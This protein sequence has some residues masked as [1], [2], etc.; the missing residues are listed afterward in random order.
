MLR[1]TSVI[2]SDELQFTSVKA[3]SA[4]VCAGA[5]F[6]K[7]ALEQQGYMY[8]WLDSLMDCP[9]DKVLF[10]NSLPLS[11]SSDTDVQRIG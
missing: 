1:A 5:V 6:E 2:K 11:L 10:I 4:V 3:M 9:D 7:S 8:G